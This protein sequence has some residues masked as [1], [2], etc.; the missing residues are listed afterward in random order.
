VLKLLGKISKLT[1]ST[2]ITFFQLTNLSTATI[3]TTQLPA[4][5]TA[6]VQNLPAKE[7]I[8][9]MYEG[10][11]QVEG[12]QGTPILKVTNSGVPSVCGNI[13][14][15]SYCPRNHTIY[16]TK[17]DVKTYYEYGDA[18]LAFVVG[19]EYGHSMQKH[20]SVTP[21]NP[22][23]AELQADCLAGYYI[24]SVRNINFDEKD[25]LKI[26]NVA[27]F[28]GDYNFESNQHHGTPRQRAAAALVGVTG[29]M[30]QKNQA[31]CS[32]DKLPKMISTVLKK[33]P[34]L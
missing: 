3:S 21:E 29:Y 17:Q 8:R 4:R 23:L 12:D 20:H 11:R 6:L 7:I 2:T 14:G 10:M 1:I 5:K 33:V 34:N 32:E 31:V 26:Y 18:A 13:L 28:M 25:I 24:G 19:H 22:T 9:A 15:S 27:K 30:V 16:I